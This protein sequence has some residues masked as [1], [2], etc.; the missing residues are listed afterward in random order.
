MRGGSGFRV[1]RYSRIQGFR[2]LIGKSPKLGDTLGAW[3]RFG[4]QD[5]AA[6][7]DYRAIYSGGFNISG[8]LWGRSSDNIGIGY[9]HLNGGNQDV[10]HTHV[11]ETYVRFALSDI[12]AITGDVQY[13]KDAM[14]AGDSPQG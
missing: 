6:A 9:A 8:S 2:G 7:I 4:W 11:F 10:D 1:F 5:D 13:M 3:I 14:K 12:F